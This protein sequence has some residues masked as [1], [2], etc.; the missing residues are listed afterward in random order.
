MDFRNIKEN[1]EAISLPDPIRTRILS[2]INAERSHPVKK[3]YRKPI[4]AA[5]LLALC[6]SLPVGAAAAGRSGR[7]RDIFDWRHAVVGT[8]YDN[9][10][11][12]ISVGAQWADGA[13]IV[14]VAMRAPE[15]A[16]YRFIELLSI[17]SYQ[18]RDAH[19]KILYEGSQTGA[20]SVDTA[21]I[22]RIPM[23]NAMPNGSMLVIDTFIAEARGEQPLPIS[24]NWSVPIRLS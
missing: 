19:G 21:L 22:F 13:L 16:P 11:E 4:A 5:A 7:F 2:N 8:A 9:A 24:G 17:G 10:T 6:L 1:V 3:R 12:E 23:D 18:I 20:V 14:T 15:Q